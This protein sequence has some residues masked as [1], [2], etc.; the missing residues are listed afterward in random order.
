MVS[1]VSEHIPFTQYDVSEAFN[2]I[3]DRH[4]RGKI[5]VDI[6]PQ[7]TSN[8]KNKNEIDIYHINEKKM[9]KI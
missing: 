3:R 1:I 4:I 5:V 9:S 7:D 8:I 2:R 6:V